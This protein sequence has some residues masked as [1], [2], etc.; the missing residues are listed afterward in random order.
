[1]NKNNSLL[2]LSIMCFIFVVL[3]FSN[4]VF[5]ATVNLNGGTFNDIENG[6]NSAGSNGI[7]NL[8]NNTY[9][10]SGSGIS[11]SGIDDLVIQG[12]SN[13]SRAN[14]D[15]KLLSE[16]FKIGSSSSNITFKYINFINGN[17]SDNSAGAI[18]A[19]GTINVED[20]SFI[21][22][23]GASGSA[24]MIH[25][26][27]PG[28]QII[29]SQFIGSRCIYENATWGTPEGAAIDSHADDVIITGCYFEDNYSRNDGGAISIAL[30][31][32]TQIT[33]CVFINNIAINAGGAVYV[34]SSDF[35]IANC[36]FTN[37]KADYGG[38]I[39]SDD[40]S[41]IIDTSTF[42]NN[43]ATTAGGATYSQT[44]DLTT[45]N[46]Q[47]T[48][49]KADYGGAI[50]D[51]GNGIIDID[52]VTFSNNKANI[53]GGAIYTK[54]PDFTDSNSKYINN[55]AQYGGAIFGD[56]GSSL[57]IDSATFDSNNVL[58][59]GGA[60]YL[61]SSDLSLTNSQLQN[62]KA[63]NGG[64][65][66]I[67]TS[68]TLNSNTNIYSSNNAVNSGGAIYTLSTNTAISGS[69]FNSNNAKIGGAII[70]DSNNGLNIDSSTFE[71]NTATT[72]GALYLLDSNVLLSSSNFIN[73]SADYG[74]A[75]FN[76]N[77]STLTI[78]S[79]TFAD[80]LAKT[81]DIVSPSVFGQYPYSEIVDVYLVCGDNIDDAI[82]NDGGSV[83]I[84][85]IMPHESTARPNQKVTVNIAGIIYTGYTDSTGIARFNV[86]TNIVPTTTQTYIANYQQTTLYTAISKTPSIGVQSAPKI[87]TTIPKTISTPPI[88]I[89]GT[90]NSKTKI[91]A[92]SGVIRKI[93]SYWN[94]YLNITKYKANQLKNVKNLNS[95]TWFEWKN[96]K[97]T[98]IER[99]KRSS[100]KTVTTGSYMH[101]IKLTK[102]YGDSK[103]LTLNPCI[104]YRC[105]QGT[106]QWI[107][108]EPT[109][110]NIYLISDL[111]TKQ[112]SNY[113]EC[114]TSK[115][116][117]CHVGNKEIITHINRVIIKVYGELTPK[118]KANAYFV[119]MKTNCKYKPYTNTELGSLK[120]LRKSLTT[121]RSTRIA[122]CADQA[123]LMIALL[124]TSGIPA[125]YEHG[126]KSEKIPGHYWPRA[127]I[128]G[129]WI[130]LDSTN[131]QNG[132]DKTI[133]SSTKYP[134]TP[135]S[136]GRRLYSLGFDSED[137][138]IK[139]SALLKQLAKKQ[140]R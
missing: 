16:I 48:N 47:F 98:V 139:D 88:V 93:P 57:T 127:Y 109:T 12:N 18:H 54:S 29:N 46:S 8:G 84:D 67:D 20:C 15:G 96:G 135:K 45:T 102:S 110:K 53:A 61:Q 59:D 132:Y 100:L 115:N 62:N 125:V 112:K 22:N 94:L 108:I 131:P 113:K 24:V 101:V 74:S 71:K 51:D 11:I 72:G 97:W 91:S 33:N 23:Y 123:H 116:R 27:A 130:K 120:T 73:N 107:E 89:I 140:Y 117:F 136:V 111:T 17:G 52:T 55:N 87:T 86:Q 35:T 134:I 99:I 137:I 126:K 68:S 128:S 133:W 129:N 10:G 83:T 37:N 85:G 114:L 39:C 90:A 118:K 2:L 77:T 138:L 65:I 21:N 76:D 105:Y 5:A 40:A 58:N 106:S 6:A 56:T 26:D 19:H 41:L 66:F 82:Y 38:A 36:E 42:N 75:I 63:D 28:S 122:N 7:L 34:R 119:W 30:S 44:S 69:R 9:I 25:A 49:N 14:L 81:F 124:R 3:S 92:S 78:N 50:A 1:M 64:A 60:I 79:V 95:G 4:T 31:T 121:S 32:G 43:N 13:S 104:A 103:K 70:T 80:N